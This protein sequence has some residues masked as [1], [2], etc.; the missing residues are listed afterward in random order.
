MNY[1]WPGG[2]ATLK[3]EKDQY[4]GI[5]WALGRVGSICEQTCISEIGPPM[6]AD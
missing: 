2:P 1:S 5:S 4:N 3:Y 6:N